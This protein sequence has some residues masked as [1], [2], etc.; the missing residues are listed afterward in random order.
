MNKLS[1]KS[2]IFRT[3][4]S[5]PKRKTQSYKKALSKIKQTVFCPHC[6]NQFRL[7]PDSHF[8]DTTVFLKQPEIKSII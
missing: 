8:L 6:N 5:T 2:P 3:N 1:L 4:L 7:F